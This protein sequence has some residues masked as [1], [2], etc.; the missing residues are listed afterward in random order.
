M[1]R[2]PAA[3]HNNGV[4]QTR[5]RRTIMPILRCS[6][7]KCYYNK[8]EECTLE[9]IHVGGREAV[10]SGNTECESFRSKNESATSRGCDNERCCQPVVSIACKAEKCIHNDNLQCVADHITVKEQGEQSPKES[11]CATFQYDNN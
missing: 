7:D 9:E 11:E 10:T 5:T 4:N 3:A 2:I 8:N 6:V 1:N